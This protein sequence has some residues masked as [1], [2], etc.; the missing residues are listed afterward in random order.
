MNQFNAA[1]S[2]FG[3]FFIYITNFAPESWER[4][5]WGLDAPDWMVFIRSSPRDYLGIPA[6]YFLL[7]LV[8]CFAIALVGMLRKRDEIAGRVES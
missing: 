6:I 4:W 3:I 2:L 5:A 8:I 1:A 7:A